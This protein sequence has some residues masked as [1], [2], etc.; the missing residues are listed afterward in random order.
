MTSEQ[1]A[2]QGQVT[3]AFYEG[4]AKFLLPPEGPEISLWHPDHPNSCP[5]RLHIHH[6][7]ATYDN[8]RH[9][10]CDWRDVEARFAK[11]TG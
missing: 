6:H 2:A 5:A 3:V 11:R 7:C 10:G 4:P 8:T 1:I 9:T